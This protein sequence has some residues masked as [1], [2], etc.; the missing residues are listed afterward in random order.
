VAAAIR[1]YPI[2]IP[3]PVSLDLIFP[4]KMIMRWMG[5]TATP[6]PA[7]AGSH[8]TDPDS[9][10]ANLE[11]L[12]AV[13]SSFSLDRSPFRYSA[14]S[15]Y[16]GALTTSRVSRHP[17]SNP[18]G[19][20]HTTVTTDKESTARRPPQP[21]PRKRCRE[22]T[23]GLA[24]RHATTSAP[25]AE[26]RP[27]GHPSCF[28][29][30]RE[31]NNPLV[32]E[33]LIGA[34]RL[35]LPG[36][37]ED[38][39][40]TSAS[41]VNSTAPQQPSGPQPR[42]DVP[43]GGSSH[44]GQFGQQVP[45]TCAPVP[46]GITTALTGGAGLPFATVTAKELK[47]RCAAA[48]LLTTGTKADLRHRWHLFVEQQQQP[49]TTNPSQPKVDEATGGTVTSTSALPN[50]ELS[51]IPNTLPPVSSVSTLGSPLL[52]TIP[53]VDQPPTNTASR[54][55]GVSPPRT[56]FLYESQQQ[57]QPSS[58]A[59]RGG[60]PIARAPALEQSLPPT[61]NVVPS[62]DAYVEGIIRRGTNSTTSTTLTTEAPAAA[63]TPPWQLLV[64]HREK[65]Y[66]KHDNMLAVLQRQQT[67]CLSQVLP[68]GDFMLNVTGDGPLESRSDWGEPGSGLY[69]YL[70]PV[71]IER[72]T[73][74]DLDAS[75]K[76][77]RYT[78][79]RRLLALSPFTIV[80]WVIEGMVDA[81]LAFR[82]R[83]AVPQHSLSSSCVETGDSASL[84]TPLNP[85]ETDLG[86]FVVLSES[87]RRV[88]AACASLSLQRKEGTHFA[89]VRTRNV[90]ESAMFLKQLGLSM[91]KQQIDS[92]HWL[93]TTTTLQQARDLQKLLRAQ[94]AFPRML[95]SIRG[96]SSKLACML[97]NK[98][99]SL[100]LLWRK[101]QDGG[102]SVCDH[103]PDIQQLTVPQKKVVVLL[104]EFL[105]S[106]E[107]Y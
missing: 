43:Q 57:Q 15:A 83:N 33:L 21:H 11:S 20:V 51:L 99:G 1:R 84:M 106:K 100:Y 26:D 107:Y 35:F 82:R 10:L 31:E 68:C 50:H 79:Q 69:P 64:D 40:V 30:R 23:P 72:K 90:Q 52:V 98:Y 80:I 95:L 70:L 46:V 87:Q 39:S 38:G 88:D 14:T 28:A 73:L 47:Q 96:C 103:D 102:P 18:G 66:G 32:G 41:L 91:V 27:R 81:Q 104:T 89:V 17:S 93:D 85:G 63:T 59:L 8:G 54:G 60:T 6:R 2:P 4:Q 77:S 94:S 42:S 3:H 7:S 12:W 19:E 34:P 48:G 92:R 76:G 78:E 13:P 9:T 61:P 71:V 45:S 101:L 56:R 67:P 29:S 22:A 24:E 44:W 65:V 62:P 74:A 37:P 36:I 58:S 16:H 105:L 75:I 53:R 55:G 86:R 5:S 97:V 49:Q 25:A